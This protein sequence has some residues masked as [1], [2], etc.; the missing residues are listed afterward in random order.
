MSRKKDDCLRQCIAFVTGLEWQKVPHFVRRYRG[1]WLYHLGIWGKRHGYWFIYA[2]PKML[3]KVHVAGASPKIFIGIG[4]SERSKLYH[5]VVFNGAGKCLYDGGTKIK[6]LTDVLII[7]KVVEVPHGRI[8]RPLDE[9]RLEARAKLPHV[10]GHARR[11]ACDGRPPRH[12]AKLVPRQERSSALRSRQEQAG[13][14]NRPRRGG[15]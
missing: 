6:D 8:R 13:Q 3:S 7:G 15:R 14:G 12:E 2:K 9:P 10:R 4:P 1:R 5:A 11:T